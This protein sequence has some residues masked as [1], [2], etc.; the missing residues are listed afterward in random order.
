M[1]F[2]FRLLLFHCLQSPEKSRLAHFT[3]MVG[4]E[5]VGLYL[6][7]VSGPWNLGRDLE[8]L[9]FV[10]Y[11]KPKGPVLLFTPVNDEHE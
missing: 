9:A 6:L 8:V 5:G 7:S 1:F 4:Q 10:S 2:K 11:L 3:S